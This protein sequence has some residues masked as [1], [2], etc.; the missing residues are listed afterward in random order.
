MLVKKVVFWVGWSG[1]YMAMVNHNVVDKWWGLWMTP[2][3]L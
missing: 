3:R 2:N 1:V